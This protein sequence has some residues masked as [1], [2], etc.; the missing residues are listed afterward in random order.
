MET[1]KVLLTN[2][3]LNTEKLGKQTELRD[4]HIAWFRKQ[5]VWNR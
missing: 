3:S 5:V 1:Q 4:H 2:L